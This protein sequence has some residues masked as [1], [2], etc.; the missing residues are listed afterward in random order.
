MC[1]LYIRKGWFWYFLKICVHF[2]LE[3]VDFAIFWKYVYTVCTLEKVDFAIYCKYV[4]TVCTL[5]K[6]DFDIF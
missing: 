5:K 6:V 3:K 4:Y 2:T 1:T